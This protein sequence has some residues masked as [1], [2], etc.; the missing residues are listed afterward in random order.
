MRALAIS[1]KLRVL[2]R[3]I[4]FQMTAQDLR[5]E[6][7]LF[8]EKTAGNPQRLSSKGSILSIKHNPS[9]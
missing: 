9:Y 2:S 6:W 1:V 4:R 5:G 3:K 8:Q 7:L